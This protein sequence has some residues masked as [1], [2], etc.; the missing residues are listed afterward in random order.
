[1][2]LFSNRFHHKFLQKRILHHGAQGI[3]IP[4][5]GI[6]DRNTEEILIGLIQLLQCLIVQLLRIAVIRTVADHILQQ[7]ILCRGHIILVST[8][9]SIRCHSLLHIPGGIIALFP[10]I[11]IGQLRYIVGVYPFYRDLVG[12]ALGILFLATIYNDRAGISGLCAKQLLFAILIKIF[13][14]AQ[15]HRHITVP[16]LIH[17]LAVLGT[18]IGNIQIIAL[19][20]HTVCDFTLCGVLLQGIVYGTLRFLIS[21]PGLFPDLL[22]FQSGISAQRH[23]ITGL[24]VLCCY[25]F[26][27]TATGR[28][29][30]SGQSR[31]C[32]Y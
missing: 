25:I 4:V 14:L 3:L 5:K 10:G 18:G 1:M 23:I 20:R 2:F 27:L 8:L 32:K 17:H 24:I 6:L 22:D 19:L 21:Q 12:V 29:A 11:V 9:Q 28:H 7:L 13:I 30:H 26:T 16:G 31:C 15:L